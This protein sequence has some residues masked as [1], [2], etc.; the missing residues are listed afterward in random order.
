MNQE[1]K[2]ELFW[3]LAEPMLA[4]GQAERGTMMGFA[5]LRSRDQFYASLERGTNNLI[6]K[7]PAGRVHE[8]V[9][10]GQALNFAPN[11]RVFREWALVDQVD[12][13]RW[14]ALLQEAYD[15]VTPATA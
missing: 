12:E 1:E 5:C 7:L 3:N 11:G 4:T 2:G 14:A 10:G 6:V 15:F 13:A 9:E 8:L